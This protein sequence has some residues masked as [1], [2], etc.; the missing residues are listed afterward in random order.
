MYSLSEARMEN[1]EIIR[2]NEKKP[3]ERIY[4]LDILRIISIMA[5]LIVH[6]SAIPVGKIESIGTTHW[7][8]ANVMN[9]GLRWC[10]PIFFMI[11]G[12]LLLSSKKEQDIFV[13]YKKS[14]KRLFLPFFT[15]SIIYFL[16]KY[17]YLD[18][19]TPTDPS[20]MIGI[21]FKE[22][23]FD[24]IYSHLWFMYAILAMYLV[25]PFLKKTVQNLK[26]KEILVF[27][28]IWAVISFIYPTLQ[29]MYTDSGNG[30]LEIS[31]LENNYFMGYV[32]YFVL[33][34]YLS[35]YELKKASKK[36]IH[37]LGFLSAISVPALT[38]LISVDKLALDERFYDNFFVTS[39][40]MAISVYIYMKDINWSD[41]LNVKMRVLVSSLSE[42][43]FGIYLSHVVVY[44]F[45]LYKLGLSIYENSFSIIP[46]Y[47]I[48]LLFNYFISYILVKILGLNSKLKIMFVG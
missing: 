3:I 23:L 42:A 28:I 40:F 18:M 1:K 25:I 8:I 29:W 39:L 47:V 20:A 14:F 15:W 43:T 48:L 32:G 17:Y 33:G 6:I 41:I 30:Y 27:L 7:W 37:V 45:G 10:V 13:F 44:V 26:Q 35:K 9:G 16:L 11:S 21:F 24:D 5:V 12:A 34:Y 22:F 38:Y 2:G 36:I 46:M 19:G 31:F 4:Y